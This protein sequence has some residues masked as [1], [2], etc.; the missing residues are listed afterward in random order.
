MRLSDTASTRIPLLGLLRQPSWRWSSTACGAVVWVVALADRCADAADPPVP[1]PATNARPTSTRA[2]TAS[3]TRRRP[4]GGASAT[5]LTSVTASSAGLAA[6]VLVGLAF[7][8]G[9][10]T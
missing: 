3:A 4:L 1:R 6:L 8:A 2:A 10:G 7:V 9:R 5:A